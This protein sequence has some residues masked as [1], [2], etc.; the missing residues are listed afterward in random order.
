MTMTH[1][2]LTHLPLTHL[3]LTRLTVT[4][5]KFAGVALAAAMAAA[6]GGCAGGANQYVQD[7]PAAQPY[8]GGPLPRQ[9]LADEVYLDGTGVTARRMA[10]A[11]DT[12]VE[13]L[14]V[15]PPAADGPQ[16]AIVR[17]R[18]TAIPRADDI[19]SAN[20]G[21]ISA[22]TGSRNSATT[23]ANKPYTTEWL[24]RENAADERLRSRMSICRGC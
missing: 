23:D 22:T 10:G 4:R 11:P 5:L 18:P 13:T 6:L 16:H 9:A 19:A 17:S 14:R 3:P 12:S 20:T 15:T 7:S 2:P 1:L 8:S 24:A 21:S